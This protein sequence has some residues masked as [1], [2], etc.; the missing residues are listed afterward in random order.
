M[1][2]MARYLYQLA[3]ACCLMCGIPSLSTIRSLHWHE[4]MIALAGMAEARSLFIGGHSA[5]GHVSA[6]PTRRRDKLAAD[7]VARDTVGTPYGG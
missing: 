2:F 6:L 1:G 7:R 3:T 5:G 4:S